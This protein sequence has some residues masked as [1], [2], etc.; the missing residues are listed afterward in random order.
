MYRTWNLNLMFTYYKINY[1]V[2]DDFNDLFSKID[3]YYFFLDR[4]T[5]NYWTINNDYLHNGF[6][7]GYHYYWW[8]EDI[9]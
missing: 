1:V 3:L 8:D 2:V 7:V 4:A 6:Q 5:V 9:V